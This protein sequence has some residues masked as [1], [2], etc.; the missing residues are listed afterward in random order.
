VKF[1][2]FGN[3]F[4]ARDELGALYVISYYCGAWSAYY[5]LTGHDDVVQI[6]QY[7]YPTPEEATRAAEAFAARE[8]SAR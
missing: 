8:A 5:Q 4:A 1:Q 7:G 3:A 2:R 6:G